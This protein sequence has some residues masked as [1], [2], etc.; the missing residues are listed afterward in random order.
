[1]PPDQFDRL[2]QDLDALYSGAAN[3]G[4][5]LLLEGGLD[6]RPMSLSPADLDFLEARN[7]AA[8]EIALALG[9]PPQLLGIPGDNTYANYK[10]ANL[11]FWRMTV[12]PLAEKMA[13]S[14]SVCLDWRGPRDEPVPVSF[15]DEGGRPWPVCHLRA[16]EGQLSWVRRGA[17]LPESWALPEGDNA[18]KFAVEFDMGSGFTGETRLETPS[19]AIPSGAITARVAEIG[20]DGRTGPWVSI[21][22]GTP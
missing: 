12:L 4:R 19:A 14:L 8:R 16:V 3:A 17:D 18:G 21:P 1:M 7:S 22:L 15:A 6:W 20:A 2:K 10:E 5:P 13:A 9:V 11:A